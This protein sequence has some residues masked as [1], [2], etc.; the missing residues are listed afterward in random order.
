MEKLMGHS[1]CLVSTY[2]LPCF[3]TIILSS[4]LFIHVFF[5]SQNP[6]VIGLRGLVI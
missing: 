6:E 3:L 1:S 4:F 5:K 2:D